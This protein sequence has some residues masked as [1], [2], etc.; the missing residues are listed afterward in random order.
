MHAPL[1]FDGLVPSFV[2]NM[3]QRSHTPANIDGTPAA[4]IRLDVSE[5]D[6]EY[7]VVA[8]VP[9]VRREDL[10]VAVEGHRLFISAEV[11]KHR[12][13]EHART[14]RPLARETFHGLIARAVVLDVEVDSQKAVARLSDGLLRLTLPKRV[15]SVVRTIAV[16]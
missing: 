16:E 10:R 14:G 9:G 4:D 13:D 5:N 11:D 12:E 7:L 3:L 15:G 8:E 2:R 1:R 6:R